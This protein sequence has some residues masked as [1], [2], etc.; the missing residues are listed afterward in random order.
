MKTS[1]CTN[2]F[3]PTW[4]KQVYEL[5][6]GEEAPV[7][8]LLANSP[9]A[10]DADS[11]IAGTLTYTLLTPSDTWAL[12]TS[13][14]KIT[15]KQSI[16]R[17]TLDFYTLSVRV[18]DGAVVP[19]SRDT[20][21][22]IKVLDDN[23]NSPDITSYMSFI[24]NDQLPTVDGDR[25][26]GNVHE[27]SPSGTLLLQMNATD[28]DIGENARLTYSIEFLGSRAQEAKEV[29]HFDTVTGILSTKKAMLYT[30]TPYE[31]RITVS[32]NSVTN[33]ES[34]TT[35]IIKCVL[36][37]DNDFAPIFDAPSYE[38]GL[39]ETAAVGKFVVQVSAQDDDYGDNA[40]ISYYIVSGNAN[41][42]FK[43]NEAN[44][45]LTL[46]GK[47]DRD[48]T[49]LYNLVI[50]AQ[51]HGSP[52]RLNVT[53]NVVV[54]VFQPQQLPV[55]WSTETCGFISG[56]V[57]GNP[58]AAQFG[59]FSQAMSRTS[60]C[61]VRASLAGVPSTPKTVSFKLLPA[62]SVE[63]KLLSHGNVWYDKRKVTVTMQ[64][65]D[66]DFNTNTQ[67]APLKVK[68]VPSSTLASKYASPV[69]RTCTPGS[70]SGIC[71]VTATLPSQWFS[72]DL[73]KTNTVTVMYGFA[74]ERIPL[75]NLEVLTTHSSPSV[76][77]ATDVVMTLP[78][79]VLHPGNTFSAPVRAHAGFK[80]NAGYAIST[81]TVKVE[82][83]PELRITSLSFDKTKWSGEVVSK[84][85]RDYV[86]TAVL[87]DSVGAPKGIVAAED[88]FT[89]NFQIRSSS[90]LSVKPQ[91][92]T[93]ILFLSNV[94]EGK[95]PIRGS[96]IPTEGVPGTF[97]D[98]T[99]VGQQKGLVQIEPDSHQ[100]TF[101]Y[102]AQ[103]E[104]VNTAVLTGVKVSSAITVKDM[105][106]TGRTTTSVSPS[107][108]S[109]NPSAISVKTDCLEVYLL[110]NERKAS[111][112]V[113]I[114]VSS[115]LQKA[116]FNV[117]VWLP[118]TPVTLFTESTDYELNKVGNWPRN[119]SGSCTTRYQESILRATTTFSDGDKTTAL[120][121]VTDILAKNKRI[122]SD[123]NVRATVNGFRVVAKSPGTFNAV[124]LSSGTETNLGSV[125]YI[126]S[127]IDSPVVK[128]EGFSIHDI[129]V[130]LAAGSAAS[131]LEYTAMLSAESTLNEV[132]SIESDTSTI[133]IIVVFDDGTRMELNYMEGL[134][135][136]TLNHLVAVPV[137]VQ[138]GGSPLVRA[139]S[140]GVGPLITAEIITCAT[141]VADPIQI[142]ATFNLPMPI[143]AEFTTSAPADRITPAGD[144]AASSGASI[145][146][147]ASLE[148][149]LIFKG[150]RRQIMTND[151]RTVFNVSLA[152]GL[153]TVEKVGGK[154][155]IIPNKD[156]NFFGTK[157]LVIQWDHTPGVTAVRMITV[158]G[159]QSL[160][161]QSTP[162]PAYPGSNAKAETDLSAL[163]NT[164]VYQKAEMHMNLIMTDGHTIDVSSASAT[165]YYLRETGGN[166][167]PTKNVV[168]IASSRIIQQSSN[169]LFEP[170][171]VDIGGKFHDRHVLGSR[172]IT[173]RVTDTPVYVTSLDNIHF[174]GTL[175]GVVGSG[176]TSRAT[177]GATF[178]DET[179]LVS[180][181]PNADGKPAVP[182]LIKWKIS[183]ET[184]ATIDADKGIARVLAN[185]YNKLTLTALASASPTL[186]K[187]VTS[188]FATNLNPGVG[189][190]DFGATNGVP[191]PSVAEGKEFS[192]IVRVNTGVTALGGID[193]R[194]FYD[195]SRL[196]A[197]GAS[198]SGTNWPGGLFQDS[199]NTDRNDG[200][201]EI[202]FG[203]T[204]DLSSSLKG[205]KSIAKLTFR[206]LP[207]SGGKIPTK[208][209]GM[210]II[211]TGQSYTDTSTGTLVQPD[212][213]GQTPR[214]I[215]AGEA[216]MVVSGSKKR[217]SAAD[218]RVNTAI[219]ELARARERRRAPC[220]NPPCTTEQCGVQGRELGDTNG[221]CAFDIN[222]ISY[223]QI[224]LAEKTFN[225][226]SQRG[227]AVQQAIQKTADNGALYWH[228][229][230][231]K[232]GY[233]QVGA[234]DADQNGI[235][236]PSDAYYM[237]RV[238]F[239]LIH[240]LS[241]V[242]VVRVSQ[243][244]N[245]G[246][247]I[248]A[249]LT[250]AKDVSVSGDKTSVFLD[251]AY[252]GGVFDEQLD[253]STLTDGNYV[254]T[255]K[256]GS[257]SGK[258]IKMKSIGGGNFVAGFSTTMIMLENIGYSI[259]Q[260][261]VNSD[262][263]GSLARSAGIFGSPDPIN[264]KFVYP[265]KLDVTLSV[266]G[267]GVKMLA[268]QGY[269]PAGYV[270]NDYPSNICNYEGT[271]YDE[272]KI[273][274][275][276]STGKVLLAASAQHVL[277]KDGDI[278]YSIAPESNIDDKFTIGQT[279]G[280]LVLVKSLDYE[281]K[282]AYS[283]TI[284]VTHTATQKS[285]KSKS[286]PILVFDTN[287]FSPVF[288]A[289]KYFATI[290]ESTV[291]GQKLQLS[292]S[293]SATDSDAGL[294]GQI[295]N[296]TLTGSDTVLQYFGV[297]SA[298]A[299]SA[300]IYLK[301]VLDRDTL[302]G[303]TM[304]FGI[305]VT[306]R[307]IVPFSATAEIE[308]GVSDV[309]DNAPIFGEKLY[310]KILNEDSELG[311]FVVTVSASDGDFGQNGAIAGY[312]I[313]SVAYRHLD[314]TLQDGLEDCSGTGIQGVR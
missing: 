45:V 82:C 66:A 24:S 69:E 300:E 86:I 247:S 41:D 143:G 23:D 130:E 191:L 250:G 4:E 307:A 115:A 133:V 125:G 95:V 6:I 224:Y 129:S 284:I 32:D 282:N 25:I 248:T 167:I 295:G 43:M 273:S 243:K 172:R 60:T 200:L 149:S 233:S 22:N 70:I 211:M 13:N 62:V 51:D 223:T 77:V 280:E 52:K 226:E 85:D 163:A 160:S 209:H 311:T 21:I 207:G 197:L 42:A 103:P 287:D 93:T 236:N 105:S 203:G 94:L 195:K 310:S 188:E 33:P 214:P 90:T 126:V 9:T 170:G 230:S 266:G 10:F 254:T 303:D 313:V 292:K 18:T 304:K 123:N 202:R 179:R 299:S 276:E 48:F 219:S 80:I 309:N 26:L 124:V 156:G 27:T 238:N 153:F 286:V 262:G 98:H 245:C 127:N 113:A 229:Y 244:S 231:A 253:A 31:F 56:A 301:K 61:S 88:I 157:P 285:Q 182:E 184:K 259:M 222:D 289:S 198:T 50:M 221:D 147:S 8:A 3:P 240:F 168:E 255:A 28:E 140:S 212:I 290:P 114:T 185:H 208:L 174:T 162:Y 107:C 169:P 232:S 239:G 141:K 312:Q 121:D 135:L 181:F 279:S 294:N 186:K 258:I 204:T 110:G 132:V 144:T 237:L 96:I 37:D 79:Y 83:G 296:F 228:P 78:A 177:I 145:P 194:V 281:T 20:V 72:S 59:F 267:Y 53:T 270:G 49:S 293:I 241:N 305:R 161:L 298:G 220:A 249:T 118:N 217:R 242:N 81:F 16:D 142:N 150:G 38:S 47:L 155:T 291:I 264:G 120:L 65:R 314:S 189:D 76:T 14:A 99:G 271:V 275:A 55:R 213:G 283:V 193:I 146:T 34:V 272:I 297:R 190:V 104:L 158:A 128:I 40:K 35:P 87:S 274:E 176:D 175:S 256:G 54:T 116:V 100:A 173:M 73:P 235:V 215:I 63:G 58:Y 218:I 46:A 44:G 5:T 137:S 306:D 302:S 97:V 117:K 308:I 30:G 112:K 29:F 263:E 171:V 67:S 216:E 205:T 206:A 154:W 180:L 268:P 17:E 139:M 183:D 91:I 196:K 164:K 39:L 159:F 109:E 187:E 108:Q 11:G 257:H 131:D 165:S 251:L 225:F 57:T 134:K 261:T 260:A 192:V 199:I 201:G 178:S 111:N 64:K 19:Q 2:S 36:L 210:V 122:V 7:G 119:E 246:F 89:A 166:N 68:M 234:M 278:A 265:N 227:K 138:P 101:A 102:T 136:S 269:N 74:D 71:T 75:K 148:V 1:E 92:T 288:S 252:D 152:D 151:P 106:R 84:S 15:L 277:M 12:D